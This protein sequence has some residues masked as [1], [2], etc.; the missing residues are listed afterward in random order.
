MKKEELSELCK[1]TEGAINSYD[2]FRSRRVNNEN[3][4]YFLDQLDSIGLTDEEPSVLLDEGQRNGIR[5]TL[6]KY[7]PNNENVYKS[8]ILSLRGGGELV[9]IGEGCGVNYI[10]FGLGVDDNF[11][12][13]LTDVIGCLV[14]EIS[15]SR[16]AV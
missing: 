2:P 4:T 16:V 11:K 8:Y 3:A 13:Q 6:N 9:T 12:N 14:K 1:E 15:E 10:N 7:S 5:V